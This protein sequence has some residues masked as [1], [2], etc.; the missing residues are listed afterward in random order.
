[1]QSYGAFCCFRT[2]PQ[3]ENTQQNKH[4][5]THTRGPRRKQTWHN[6]SCPTK[7]R[8]TVP[9]SP[10]PSKKVGVIASNMQLLPNSKLVPSNI[11][12]YFTIEFK[13]TLSFAERQQFPATLKSVHRSLSNTSQGHRPQQLPSL[14]RVFN[15][16]CRES[17]HMST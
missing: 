2:T 10:Q 3:Q 8:L 5:H 6:L 7:T 17:C 15:C 12:S 11:H 13:T 4:P 1:M 9:A 14:K 16:V